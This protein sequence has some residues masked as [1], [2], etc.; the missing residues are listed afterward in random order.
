MASAETCQNMD[1]FFENFKV[2]KIM[3]HIVEMCRQVTEQHLNIFHT[4]LMVK[5]DSSRCV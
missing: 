1:W 2:I 3:L 5:E 4:M